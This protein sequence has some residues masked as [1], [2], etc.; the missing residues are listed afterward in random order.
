MNKEI[1]KILFPY[2]VK[3]FKGIFDKYMQNEDYS[4]DLKIIHS[5]GNLMKEIISKEN[6]LNF[7]LDE[8]NDESFLKECKL[9]FF[10]KLL[11]YMDVKEE[12][13][14]VKREEKMEKDMETDE[15]GHIL[16]NKKNQKD[17]NNRYD[18]RVSNRRKAFR[19]YFVFNKKI[20]IINSYRIYSYCSNI[21]QSLPSLTYLSVIKIYLTNYPLK[22]FLSC[23]YFYTFV[24]YVCD[25]NNLIEFLESLFCSIIVTIG[26][27]TLTA[28][29]YVKENRIISLMSRI[30]DFKES[31]ICRNFI[32]N[33]ARDEMEVSKFVSKKTHEM[34]KYSKYFFLK[35]VLNRIN[36]ELYDYECLKDSN[37]LNYMK[38]TFKENPLTQYSPVNS[39]EEYLVQTMEEGDRSKKG[40][41]KREEENRRSSISS[42]STKA[43][44]MLMGSGVPE[45][46][47]SE[48]IYVD[49]E[50]KVNGGE[51]MQMGI[52]TNE[53]DIEPKGNE[54][55]KKKKKL[56]LEYC[57]GID[58]T[59]KVCKH[60]EDK[61]TINNIRKDKKYDHMMVEVEK[62]KN[63]I[64]YI[65][66]ENNIYLINGKNILVGDIIYLFKGDIIPADGILIKGNNLIVDESNI[67]NSG[68][69]EKKKKIRLDEYIYEIERSRKRRI[70]VNEL[71]KKNFN[72]FETLNLKVK[73][74]LKRFS[75]PKNSKKGD[76][77]VLGQQMITE[78][79]H[80]N[81]VRNSLGDKDKS[82]SRGEERQ[83]KKLGEIK[84]RQFWGEKGDNLCHEALENGNIYRGSVG[85]SAAGQIVG[86]IS[87]SQIY[88]NENCG[89]LC[90]YSPLL[91]S[92]SVVTDGMGIMIATC[93][94]KN[95]QMFNN[96]I[97]NS[98]EDTKLEVLINSYSKNVV[99][100]LTFYCSLCIL[101]VFIH[102][103]INL[104]ENDMQTFAYNLLMFL[105]NAIMLEILKY[106]LLSIDQM[107]LLLQNC[108]ALNSSQIMKEN[109]IIKKKNTFEKILHTNTIFIDIQ[110]YIKYQCIYFY[111]NTEFTFATDGDIVTS[112][113][114]EE[115]N[116]RVFNKIGENE[117]V[118]SSLFFVLLIQGILTTSNLYQYNENNLPVDLSLLTFLK[119]LEINI[120]D[121]FIKRKNIIRIISSGQ[122]YIISF[123]LSKKPFLS[124]KK[125]S[126]QVS[127]V[128]L[129]RGEE[130]AYVLRIFVRGP[131]N[132][133]LPKCSQY[134]NGDRLVRNVD[135][136]R[137][138]TEKV[139]RRD[140]ELVL[141]VAY[142][143]ILLKEK[144]KESLFLCEDDNDLTFD[145]K[146]M[147]MYVKDSYLR[148]MNMNDFTC[149]SILAFE[150]K[151]SKHFYFDYKMLEANDMTVKLFTNDNLIKTK[152]LFCNFP[153]FFQNFILYNAKKKKGM[154]GE[155][156]IMPDGNAYGIN[157]EDKKKK[158]NLEDIYIDNFG[159]SSG[160]GQD[161]GYGNGNGTYNGGYQKEGDNL[162][163]YKLN[164]K[165]EE[166]TVRLNKCKSEILNL[167]QYEEGI[168]MNLLN[169]NERK[170]KEDYFILQHNVFY[171]CSS[172]ELENLLY[173]SKYYGQN[174]VVTNQ[175][176]FVNDDRI[177]S[178][179]VC[180]N[181]SKDADKAKSDIII[182]NKSLYYYIKL[183][184]FSSLYSIGGNKLKKISYDF[185]SEKDMN[186]MISS[187]LSKFT[188][189]L[190]VFLFGHLFIPESKWEFVKDEVREQFAFCEFSFF[191]DKHNSNYFHTI[192]SSIRFKKNLENIRILNIIDVK[193]DYRT[194]EE[195]DNHIS[196]SRHSTILFNLF[197]LFFFFSYIHIY[198]KTFLCEIS[199]Y[200]DKF[201]EN[202]RGKYKHLHLIQNEG[203][204]EIEKKRLSQQIYSLKKELKEEREK[205]L[206]RM[207][208][209][210]GDLNK[211]FVETKDQANYSLSSEK[212]EN[213]PKNSS[214]QNSDTQ[215]KHSA[216]NLIN[217]LST[218]HIL[219]DKDIRRILFKLSCKSFKNFQHLYEPRERSV[220]QNKLHIPEIQ[221]RPQSVDNFYFFIITNSCEFCSAWSCSSIRKIN[222]KELD[223]KT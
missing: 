122:D 8:N 202:Q 114:V 35:S 170:E 152:K 124:D 99:I 153:N 34:K 204:M 62:N 195:W 138:K 12:K 33:S 92:E 126:L 23:V 39:K 187:I 41:A 159:G 52:N 25:R 181:R 113:I 14:R 144:E 109:F 214:T 177:C 71:K 102:F 88:M 60:G 27:L 42:S 131:A 64:D 205:G 168:T 107:P 106:L 76:L 140:H 38:D 133:V 98:E 218:K 180:D 81:D 136:L 93:V 137:E 196:P 19:A 135:K 182:L 210:S 47:V 173:V 6:G 105:L 10:K 221:I 61:S 200:F 156:P 111:Y 4:K 80:E 147:Q 87:P 129:N 37:K 66:F 56:N 139:N 24:T 151:L 223:I 110:R 213:N 185:F 68:K 208:P 154:D 103:L 148:Y 67:V 46:I 162:H 191:T 63:I 188:I 112:S 207:T 54:K 165:W 198:M 163:G 43:R 179:L 65:I 44:E 149:V 79:Q 130:Q 48:G 59:E 11:K 40:A 215:N 57:S 146:E 7:Y 141:C 119:R 134:V 9:P 17:E 143:E 128:S 53:T 222:A 172:K 166:T 2:D 1:T 51:S 77:S 72:Y 50:K 3:F 18:K 192:R 82:S 217:Q 101:F 116:I 115:D 203:K 83:E 30:N 70:T 118:R 58:D 193:K 69:K 123:V 161:N 169:Q 73:M 89:K 32:K 171:N 206:K 108:I 28:V 155:G 78:Q 29:H 104:I 142:K 211:G 22:I 209:N 158:K 97:K 127:N 184:C 164:T 220:V 45:K 75:N 74:Q 49:G 36:S 157:E 160:N 199:L 167:K 176:N 216:V 132:L 85:E 201:K 94:S 194:M 121:Y 84:S 120:D 175:S 190:I 13:E 55:E 125:L 212:K 100:L 20:N 150:R 90:E 21:I 117:N 95:K 31:Y 186:N 26:C 91:L 197:F 15:H 96:T 189:L 86:G 178:L 174:A 145:N 183:K 5:S 219:T 16:Q